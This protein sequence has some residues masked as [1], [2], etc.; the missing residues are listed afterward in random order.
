MKKTFLI[1]ALLVGSLVLSGC[2][3]SGGDDVS[4]LLKTTNSGQ[5]APVSQMEFDWSNINIMGGTVSKTFTLSNAGSEDLI[6][7]GAQT[8]CM[9]TVANFITPDG[10]RSPDFGMHGRP[11]WAAVVEPGETFDIEV[12]FDPLAHGPN[13]TG[14]ITRVV[15]LITSSQI[16]GNIAKSTMHGVT[17]ELHLKGNVL[18]ESDFK[19]L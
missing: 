16:D 10:E 9:C 6:L 2:S 8:S 4:S 3:S 11:K 18:S 19:S 15:S 1:A 17:T 14:P 12:V 5:I 13:G 7:Q